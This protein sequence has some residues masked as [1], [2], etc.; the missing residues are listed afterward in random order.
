MWNWNHYF[1]FIFSMCFCALFLVFSSSF[2]T[3]QHLVL[4]YEHFLSLS[5]ANESVISWHKAWRQATLWEASHNWRRHFRWA[6]GQKDHTVLH[7]IPPFDRISAA[8]HLAQEQ[9]RVHCS[10]Q[11]R[12]NHFLCSLPE[13]LILFLQRK[14]M[15]HEQCSQVK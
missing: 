7:Y 1:F 5:A 14:Q 9:G 3:L 11:P 10:A 2:Y 6:V 13:K 8:L 12:C 15:R 4:T